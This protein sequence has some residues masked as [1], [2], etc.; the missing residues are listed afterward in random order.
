MST[1]PSD[2]EPVGRIQEAWGVRGWL[3]LLPYGSPKESVLLH[4]RCW[5]LRPQQ[6]QALPVL[7]AAQQALRPVVVTHARVHGATVVAHLEDLDDRAQAEDL[8]TFE[9]LVSR[10]EFPAAAE[11]EYYWVDLVGCRV[12]NR[13]A[14]DLGEV[15]AVEDHGAHALLRVRPAGA[16]EFMIPFV[17]AHVDSVDLPGRRILVD[18]QA[19]YL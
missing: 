14:Q 1:P 3:K 10:A 2:L 18:W 9:V 11:G 12:V 13:E 16:D 6:S 4:A 19:D 17:A 5:W 8:R 7:S 15:H